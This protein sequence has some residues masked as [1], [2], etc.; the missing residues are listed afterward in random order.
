[1][2]KNDRPL[3]GNK[4]LEREVVAELFLSEDAADRKLLVRQD[5]TE[6][7]TMSIFQAIQKHGADITGICEMVPGKELEIAEILSR[8]TTAVNIKKH[9]NTLRKL[10]IRRMGILKANKFIDALYSKSN[11]GKSIQELQ[12]ALSSL[13]DGL[14]ENATQS[15]KNAGLKILPDGISTGFLTWDSNDSGLKPGRITLLKG[16]RG[17]GK[18]TISRQVA[19]SAARQRKN[20]FMFCGETSIEEEKSSLT[21]LGC[22]NSRILCRENLG[23]RTL[24]Y[25]SPDA[26]AEFDK[27]FGK[28]I[29]LSDSKISKNIDNLWETLKT[30]IFS[31]I[32][33][34]V[35]LV[36]IDS[37]MKINNAPGAKKF[38]EQ[39]KI[40]QSLKNIATEK[41]IHIILIVHPSKYNQQTSGVSEQENLVDTIVDYSRIGDSNRKY[42]ESVYPYNN[43]EKISAIL[44]VEKI[45]DQGGNE[46]TWLSWDGKKGGVYEQTSK[47]KAM[48]YENAGHWVKKIPKYSSEEISESLPYKDN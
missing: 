36:I 3:P 22:C 43:F 18:T 15:A 29:F 42:L 39:K 9:I 38:T 46:V 4:K 37:M 8:A 40:I 14:A 30:Q 34:G 31:A 23:G 28:F 17:A 13:N 26:E 10:T 24:F 27:K 33:S 2:Q 41:N 25:P 12:E 19:V 16:I 6:E 1:M 11:P 44:T 20:V 5:F 32:K 21:R 47:T 7:L 45:R 48:E 35:E